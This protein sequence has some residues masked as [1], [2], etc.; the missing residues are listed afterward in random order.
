MQE[1]KEI[2]FDGW[3]LRIRSGELLRDGVRIRLQERPLQILE[4]LLTNPGELV[5][6]EQLIAHLWPTGVVDFDTGLNTAMRKLRIALGDDAE[7]PRYIETIP[8]R[9]YRFIGKIEAIR[10]TADTGEQNATIAP[11]AAESAPQ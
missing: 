7:T 3:I 6:R 4:V 5:T 8:R 9:G 2:Q 11:S 1:S 10:R